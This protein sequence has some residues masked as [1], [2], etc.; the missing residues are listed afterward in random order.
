MASE[1]CSHEADTLK[2]RVLQSRRAPCS[3]RRSPTR[4][5]TNCHASFSLTVGMR[6]AFIDGAVGRDVATAACA[7][8]RNAKS[9]QSCKIKLQRTA[10]SGARCMPT[11]IDRSEGFLGDSG[12]APS[13]ACASGARAHSTRPQTLRKL[14]P[15]SRAK[16]RKHSLAKGK[17]AMRRQPPTNQSG[18]TREG[19]A[20]RAPGS[21]RHIN[22]VHPVSPTSPEQSRESR[23]LASFFVDFD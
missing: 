23:E 16:L 19:P 18:C 22:G 7:T 20:R 14:A 1:L 13:R 17:D 2:H 12:S 21:R 3:A 9:A 4:A 5:G 6:S 11:G 10:P 15:N 8:R